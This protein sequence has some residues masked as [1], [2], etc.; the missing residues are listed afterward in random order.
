MRLHNLAEIFKRLGMSKHACAVYEELQKCP[1]MSATE[2]VV[3]TGAHRPAVYK[4]ID[5]LMDARLI[6]RSQKGKR[7]V[8]EARPQKYVLELFAG[9]ARQARAIVPPA[10]NETVEVVS[11]NIKLLHGPEGI[12]AVFDDVVSHME[13]AGTFCRY[14]SERDLDKVNSYLSAEYRVLRDKKRL[15]RMV[16]SNHTSGSRKRPRLERFIKYIPKEVDPFDQNI[17]QLIYGART[18]FIDLNIEEAYIIENAALAEFQKVIFK[19]L[20]RRL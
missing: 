11:G 15:D 10:K 17:I 20:Y 9:V 12:R 8:Y 13:R 7:F 14:T 1:G 19:Q 5:E 6:V 3:A 16:I 18:A 2:I 4:A